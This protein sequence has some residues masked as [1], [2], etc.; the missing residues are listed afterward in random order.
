MFKKAMGLFVGLTAVVLA[1][2]SLSPVAHAG[3]SLKVGEA[4]KA[5]AAKMVRISETYGY[6]GF[7]ISKCSK[8]GRM[9]AI[10]VV[11]AQA[12]SK[13]EIGGCRLVWAVRKAGK[14][15]KVTLGRKYCADLPSPYLPPEAPKEIDPDNPSQQGPGPKY[16]PG[17]VGSTWNAK[18]DFVGK[19]VQEATPIAAGNGCS[20]RVVKKDGESL[21][22]TMDFSFNRINVEVEGPDEL[23][24]AINGIY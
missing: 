19:T 5:T 6:D 22:I 24:T 4:R 18:A 1:G 21:I 23:I 14:R 13:V 15:T 10:C 11:E 12:G 20:V 8:S 16:C 9:K 3:D 17:T 7:D 2:L